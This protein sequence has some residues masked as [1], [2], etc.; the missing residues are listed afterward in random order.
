MASPAS[1][2]AE[3]ASALQIRHGPRDAFE[4][5]CFHHVFEDQARLTPERP[6]VV[7]AGD[8]LTYAELN[9]RANQIARFIRRHGAGRRCVALLVDRSMAMIVGLLGILKAGSA[10]VPLMAGTPPARI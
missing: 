8:M 3:A 7:C 10:Y 2:V 1:L 5:T 9:A 4:P 6:A